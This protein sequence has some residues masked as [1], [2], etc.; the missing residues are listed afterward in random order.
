MKKYLGT[1]LTIFFLTVFC[2]YFLGNLS[3]FKPLLD[4]SL[5]SLVLIG[6]LKIIVIFLNGL[7]IKVTLKSFDKIITQL[8]T[9]YISLLSSIGNYFT[10]MQGGAGIRAV[11]LKKKFNLAYSHFL[12]TLS[13]NYIISFLINSLIG[14]VS[15]LL[16]HKYQGHY[17]GV[18]YG[19][20]IAL[21]IV[22]LI[23]SIF[24]V[25]PKIFQINLKLKPLNRILKII[26]MIVE[27]WNRIIGNKTFLLQLIFLTIANFCIGL[28]TVY[29]EFHIFGI[30][31]HLYNLTLYS[32]L[33]GVTLLIS[34]TP[35]SIG[36][37]EGVFIFSSTL[38]G[39][40]HE[41]ILQIAV[42]DRG[43]LFFV[44]VVSYLLIKI[45]PA[46]KNIRMLMRRNGK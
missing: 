5:G 2:I 6:I 1:I 9:F 7:F 10:P 26:L 31:T 12:S 40:T 42:V 22:T 32:A 19:F 29:W 46:P 23:L 33:A 11:Y 30:E 20:F 3:K 35:G 18:L 38:I 13:G 37:R 16:V 28:F 4:I 45:V 43:V 24:K 27:G 25:P 34:L 15:L 8:E 21:F 44:L 14:L 17:S 39:I 41:E 36:I